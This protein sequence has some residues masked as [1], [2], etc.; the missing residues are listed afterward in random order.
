MPGIGF[1]EDGTVIVGPDMMTGCEG[2]FAG[3]DMV[4]SERSVTVAIGHGKKAARYIDGFLRGTPYQ[5]PSKHPVV[6]YER[7]HLWYKTN[8][9]QKEQAILPVE[10]RVEGFDEIKAGLSKEEALFESQRCLSC[11]NCF[12]CDGCYG[13]CPE[14]AIIKLGP[15][16]G[17]QYNFD[18]C[19]GCA[20][21]YEQCPCHAI[22]M[23][24]EP[25]NI[26]L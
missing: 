11:G 15:G 9:P 13:A 8:A 17:Y 4:P 1:K 3:G 2:V 18:R 21:C 23:I 10:K 24:P 25:K 14:D 16:N 6:G 20:I 5:K 12:E 19:T 22:E 7:L 26:D